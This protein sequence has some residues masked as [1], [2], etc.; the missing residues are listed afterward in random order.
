MGNSGRSETRHLH[1]ELGSG[2]RGAS[3]FD[4]CKGSKSFDRIYDPN[5][6]INRQFNSNPQV[7]TKPKE[8]NIRA[9][10]CKIQSSS[11]DGDMNVR[12]G[13]GTTNKILRSLDN[14]SAVKI[15]SKSG[16]WYGVEF[17][18]DGV[19][20][21]KSKGKPAYIHK[22]GVN[23]SKTS[24]GIDS[25]PS[26]PAPAQAPKP[27]PKPAPTPKPAPRTNSNAIRPLPLH[28]CKVSMNSNDGW[29]NVRT[30]PSS[31]NRVIDELYQGDIVR[32][33]GFVGSWLSVEYFSPATG[34]L[35]AKRGKPAFIHS[36]LLKCKPVGNRSTSSNRSPSN[37]SIR[38][39]EDQVKKAA[40]GI[41]FNV[42]AGQLGK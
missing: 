42:I 31:N 39:T 41:L 13:A 1:F 24:V 12:S 10:W 7:D 4:A 40:V 15:V 23:C 30:G 37:N 36:S 14:G 18:I 8:T 35:G 21:G 17:K 9:K 29:A 3:K 2:V 25:T 16:D 33:T 6:A 5:L 38:N 26:A 20:Y 32:A 34:Q 22:N 27:E 28:R 19:N 11:S